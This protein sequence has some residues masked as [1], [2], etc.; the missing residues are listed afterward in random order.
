MDYDE[1]RH[2]RFEHKENG[3]MLIA[4]SCPEKLHFFDEK[5]VEGTKAIR[6][7]RLPVFP[8]TVDE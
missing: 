6:E 4:I 2:L 5:V 7:K 1:R 8:S 3:I